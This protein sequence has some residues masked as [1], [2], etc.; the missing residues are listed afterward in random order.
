MPMGGMPMMAAPGAGGAGEGDG[1][2]EPVEEKLNFDV[3]LTG[4]DA[5]AKIKIIKE[6]RSL[7]DLGLKEAKELVESAPKPVKEAAAKDEAEDSGRSSSRWYHCSAG[8]PH[9][10]H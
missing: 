3:K 8:R 10:C 6:V 9:Y 7:T 5:K 2:A 1:G 4:F